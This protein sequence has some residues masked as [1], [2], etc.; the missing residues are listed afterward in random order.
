M[1][2]TTGHLSIPGI[3]SPP[4]PPPFPTY[5]THFPLPP[6]T[7]PPPSP[8]DA[9]KSRTVLFIFKLI[10]EQLV[11]FQKISFGL[12]N[13]Y[14]EITNY[15]PYF[16]VYTVG[17]EGIG[18]RSIFNSQHLWDELSS[19]D[20]PVLNFVFQ[21]TTATDPELNY[22]DLDHAVQNFLLKRIRKFGCLHPFS[23]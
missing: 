1:L 6:L 2:V 4:L 23:A 20:L 13:F 11:S 5:P 3:N 19:F 16:I 21:F 22:E 7:Y 8:V 12:G 9:K 14:F 15:I 18:K 10:V 17:K